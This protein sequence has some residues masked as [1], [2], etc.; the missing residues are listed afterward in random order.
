MLYVEDPLA[1]IIPNPHSLGDS[2]SDACIASR[3]CCRGA[4]NC[5]SFSPSEP[6]EAAAVYFVSSSTKSENVAASITEE[7]IYSMATM[8]G[9]STILITVTGSQNTWTSMDLLTSSPITTPVTG[10]ALSA[11]GIT[12]VC[13]GTAISLGLFVGLIFFFSQRFRRKK[14][15]QSPL[16]TKPSRT[17]SYPRHF[18]SPLLGA[19]SNTFA[20]PAPVYS[21]YEPVKFRDAMVQCEEWEDR[22]LSMPLLPRVYG[23][24]HGGRGSTGPLGRRSNTVGYVGPDRQTRTSP[25]RVQTR[26]AIYKA[27]PPLPISSEPNERELLAASRARRLQLEINVGPPQPAQEEVERPS[28][29]PEIRFP[30]P[31]QIQTPTGCTPCRTPILR[32]S[33]GSENPKFAP[34]AKSGLRNEVGSGQTPTIAKGA[35]KEVQ[36]P[37]QTPVTSQT[38]S[39]MYAAYR[40]LL[41]RLEREED[42]KNPIS[43]PTRTHE[44]ANPPSAAPTSNTSAIQPAQTQIFKSTENKSNES[45]LPSPPGASHTRTPASPYNPRASFHPFPPTL[46]IPNT[47]H[48]RPISLAQSLSPLSNAPSGHEAPSPLSP[49]SPP[50][51]PSSQGHSLNQTPIQTTTYTPYRPSAPPYPGPPISRFSSMS[52]SNFQYSSQRLSQP[53]TSQG[54]PRY[55]P[56]FPQNTPLSRANSQSS[57]QWLSQP[58]QY[59]PRE[60]Q[61]LGQAQ[62]PQQ[63]RHQGPDALSPLASPVLSMSAFNSSNNVGG[64]GLGSVREGELYGA[65]GDG[66]G[67]RRALQKSGS[68]GNRGVGSRGSGTS[69]DSRE[70]IISGG[71]MFDELPPGLPGFYGA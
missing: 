27:Q 13:I 39:A 9:T 30:S 21:Y 22:P 67:D 65:E 3:S 25:R 26:T 55:S 15:R 32:K 66:D 42:S 49:A 2:G 48:P 40:A 10:S 36:K 60:Q 46:L 33:V 57:S 43:D 54:S 59:Q 62:D 70:S 44:P 69:R 19:T 61:G 38:P 4:F 58:P 64:G 50:T 68:S 24:L 18:P 47:S 8:V 45:P 11:G 20:E 51:H 35:E 16:V 28:F 7:V 5:V 63:T 41:Q 56:I 31:L 23:T 34:V 37:L 12:G 29:L 53:F 14:M 71:H 6:F 17:P 52:H 1:S